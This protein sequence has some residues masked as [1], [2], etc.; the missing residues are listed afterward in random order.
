MIAKAR[1]DT[2]SFPSVHS[3]WVSRGGSSERGL[4]LREKG[5]GGVKMTGLGC[6]DN[7][8]ALGEACPWGLASA[9]PLPLQS[10]S[11]H[12]PPPRRENASPPFKSSCLGLASL[13]EWA[14][15]LQPCHLLPLV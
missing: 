14:P 5:L 7:L 1:E 11:C 6:G 2:V 4:E 3:S 15:A 8:P 12:P 9:Q 13:R 10:R